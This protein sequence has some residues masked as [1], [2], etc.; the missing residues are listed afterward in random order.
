MLAGS[1]FLFVVLIAVLR[2]RQKNYRWL[3]QRLSRFLNVTKIKNENAMKSLEQS[4]RKYPNVA[5]FFFK[6]LSSNTSRQTLTPDI[7]YI[8]LDGHSSQKG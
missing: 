5:P 8:E 2:M 1:L 6:R 4:Y 7:D 3:S